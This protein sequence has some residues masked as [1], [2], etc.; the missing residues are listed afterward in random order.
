MDKNFRILNLDIRYDDIKLSNKPWKPALAYV[1]FGF[2]WITFSDS[3]L[4]YFV[5]DMDTY[6]KIQMYKGWFFIIGTGF[7]LY[8]MI[9]ADNHKAYK[10]TKEIAR[11]NEELVTFSE[12]LVAMEADLE[13]QL[14]DLNALTKDIKHQKDFINEIFNSSNM[15]IMVWKPCGELV[16]CNTYFREMLQLDKSPLGAKWTEVCQLEEDDIDFQEIT[17]AI[18]KNGKVSDI[19]TEVRTE[20]GEIVNIIWNMSYLVDPVT[21]EDVIASYGA[22]IT[23]E[24]QK[25]RRLLEVATTD[26]LTS[27]K[28][29][30]A[31]ES[32]IVDWIEEKEAFT[33]YLIGLDN[34]KYLNDLYGHLYGDI[35]LEKMGNVLSRAFSGCRIYKWS[36]DEFLIVD[37]KSEVGDVNRMIRSIMS[38]VINKWSLK[39]IEYSSSA[40]VGIVR[41]PYNG[42]TLSNLASNL[43]IALNHAKRN[44]RGQHQFFSETFM[45]S[46]RYEADLEDALSTAILEDDLEL[47][48]QPIYDMSTNQVVSLEALLRWPNNPLNES[49][50]GRVI[51]LAEKTGQITV[52]DKWVIRKVFE[53]IQNHPASMGKVQVSINISVQS[54]HSKN[55]TRFL[56]EQLKLYEVDPHNI[57]L[58]ITEYSLAEDINKSAEI[59]HSIKAL[60]VKIALDDFGTKYSSLNYLSK[61]SFDVLKIDKSYID[62]IMTDYKD[63]AIVKHLIKLSS[64]LS[65]TTIVEG[66]ENAEQSR[67]L[68]GMGCQYGQGYYYC[69]PKPLDEILGIFDGRFRYKTS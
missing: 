1:I 24:R 67:I 39:D 7:M 15:L 5:S 36:G 66:I 53:D 55:F 4:S 10:M 33:L 38:L 49:N 22:N 43:D 58:E 9:K 54:F 3:V 51:S 32:E 20:A 2:L 59:I 17:Q 35:L 41:Y 21:K 45:E 12:E 40:S 27:L 25:E 69:K 14:V 16:N 6:G 23:G 28:N 64:D 42:L 30:A 62:H 68:M 65:L 37:E 34:F 57:E 26:P 11:K 63:Q 48:Y 50:I 8:Y 44:G 56:Q 47:N 18:L 19:E 52:I 60:G 13:K 31:F 46:I 61:L 29:R